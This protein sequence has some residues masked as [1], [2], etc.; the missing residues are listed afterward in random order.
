[1]DIYSA[2]SHVKKLLKYVEGVA[3]SQSRMYEKSKVRLRDLAA[4][5]NQVVQVISGILQERI[6]ESDESEFDSSDSDNSS[7]VEGLLLSMQSE[8]DQ[9]KQFVSCKSGSAPDAEV[10]RYNEVNVP[11]PVDSSSSAKK[12][13][14]SRYGH[15]LSTLASSE[16]GYPS[17]CRCAKLLWQW[18]D[19]RFI[20]SVK[21]S[22]GTFRYSLKRLPQ[23][24]RDIVMLYGKSVSEGSESEFLNMFDQ[25]CNDLLVSPHR[26]AVPYEVYEFDKELRPNDMTLASAVIWDILLDYGLRALCEDSDEMYLST[27]SVYALIGEHAPDV[28]DNYAD[29]KYN[30]SV[31]RHCNLLK[32]V[33]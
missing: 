18:Y 14:I 23:W 17:V 19:T 10:S 21:A 27:N 13:A 1:M 30:P 8:L 9:L 29:Y 25:W 3:E 12:R 20:R 16:I 22:P 11:Q 2:E 6:L 7:E 33:I 24:V 28:L 31:L 15:I 4:T 26:Y 5:C 32:E